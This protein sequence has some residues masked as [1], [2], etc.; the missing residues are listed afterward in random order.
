MQAA[1][2]AWRR[3][4]SLPGEGI[5]LPR[6]A[7]GAPAVRP[8]QRARRSR[9]RQG[10]VM[11]ERIG[12]A[13]EHRRVTRSHV[14]DHGIGGRLTRPARQSCALP[15]ASLNGRGRS[16]WRA[17]LRRHNTFQ[18]RLC[19]CPRPAAAC[20]SPSVEASHA[21]THACP[22]A[23]RRGLAVAS[24]APA[25]CLSIHDPARSVPPLRPATAIRSGG[26]ARPKKK[27]RRRCRC[28][29]IRSRSIS[30]RIRC[31]TARCR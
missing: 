24:A 15:A 30:I 25:L 31:D 26:A 4:W 7:A 27:G 9:A 12:R 2:E 22:V 14:R 1:A 20:R 16:C 6:R 28:R 13:D 8:P 11:I 21:A 3:G 19:P 23:S 29:P 18:H 17:R 5:A 10:S